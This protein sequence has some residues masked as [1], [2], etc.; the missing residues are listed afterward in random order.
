L[1][2]GTRCDVSTTVRGVSKRTRMSSH[3]FIAR[4]P[5]GTA[6]AMVLRTTL[7]VLAGATL[8]FAQTSTES[9]RS[10]AVSVES[11]SPAFPAASGLTENVDTEAPQNPAATLINDTA[12]AKARRK[13]ALSDV[14]L[15]P[16]IS[17]PI[18][19][20]VPD[21]SQGHN[22][23][24]DATSNSTT[25]SS[26][27]PSI[28]DAPINPLP[29][30][31]NGPVFG[32]PGTIRGDFWHRTQLI[33][34]P[35]CI[36]T[37]LTRRGIFVDLYSTTAYQDTAS[38]GLKTGN[39]IVQ[40]TQLSIN[41][42][43]ARAGLWAGGLIHFTV[44]SRY[45]SS[46]NNTF[47]AGSFVPEYTGLDLP[48]P[49]FWQ[50]TLPSDYS[51]IQ[52]LGKKVIVILGKINGLFIADQ[53]LF[54]DRFRY[55]FAN[56]NLNKNVI[57]NNFF[58]TTTLAAIGVWTPTPWLTI[59]AGVH[60]P[61]TEPNTFAANAFKNGDVNLYGEAIVTFA[62]AGLPSQIVPAVNWSNAPKINL[63]SPFGQLSPAQIPQAVNVLLGN[64][65][66]DGLPTNF[67]KSSFFTISNF[68]QYLLVKEE[69]SQIAEKLR[70]AQPLRG[71]G[72]FG[73]LGYGGPEDLNPVDTD[74]SIALLA[75]GLW[76]SRQYDSFGIGFYYDGVSRNLKNSIRQLTD[77][78]ARNET[79]A[80]I[81]YN[82]AV[83]PAISVN[84]G[85]QHI[86][87]PLA[88]AVTANQ[89]HADLFMVRLNLVW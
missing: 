89:D 39:S 50:D 58:N 66:P 42:D 13:L 23:S 70:N 74:A 80:E 2:Y 59:A 14:S 9:A 67:K 30:F 8:T 45:G 46:P 1:K 76:N 12:F 48:G 35:N 55:Y 65:S 27:L 10:A 17:S 79:G 85:Y 33:G 63:G 6:G 86:W 62:I 37:D 11:S 31:N 64:D 53:T 3:Q 26:S 81:F 73:R 29:L 5:F 19:A 54:G 43:T 15:G 87:N 83:T 28:L 40:N 60:D 61:H 36:R 41:L 77:I 34:D 7:S 72:V 25:I 44:Q 38:G 52:G 20:V 78:T 24:C 56:S 75:E 69:P 4:L 49:L 71:V 22:N 68:S 47:T 57:Y 21:S 84:A 88:A 51:L 16:T 82:F 18:R 32:M